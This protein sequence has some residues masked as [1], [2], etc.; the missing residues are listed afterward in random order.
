MGDDDRA[1]RY[2]RAADELIRAIEVDGVAG[3]TFG[4]SG[5][6][7]GISNWEDRTKDQRFSEKVTTHGY[8]LGLAKS[9]RWKRDRLLVDYQQRLEQM[10]A[11]ERAVHQAVHDAVAWALDA[12]RFLGNFNRSAGGRLPIG[13][14]DA[15]ADHLVIWLRERGFAVLPLYPVKPAAQPMPD[16]VLYKD[17][18]SGMI[19]DEATHHIISTFCRC[20]IQM[21]I[22]QPRWRCRTSMAGPS[23]SGP[24]PLPWTLKLVTRTAHAARAS[25]LSRKRALLRRAPSPPVC[26]STVHALILVGR[27]PHDGCRSP[28]KYV[29]Q[30]MYAPVPAA[31]MESESGA[32]SPG[33]L[34]TDVE[35]KGWPLAPHSA[36][37]LV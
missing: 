31:S 3:G 35:E 37:S 24:N 11:G 9:T 13:Q 2:Q 14:V 36:D 26:R 1:V 32:N 34:I 4:P 33:P 22:L 29:D 30:R 18:F 8:P 23:R 28:W 25:D 27:V 6:T 21:P 10:S 19:L 12:E 5:M 20:M 15:V 7:K 17:V 16:L